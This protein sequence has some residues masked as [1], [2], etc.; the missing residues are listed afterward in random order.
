MPRSSSG[1]QRQHRGGGGPTAA[2]VES[3]ELQHQLE[4]GL[5]HAVAV[6]DVVPQVAVP[7]GHISRGRRL[8]TVTDVDR[9]QPCRRGRSVERLSVG[10]KARSGDA[11]T[12]KCSGGTSTPLA[13]NATT[14]ASDRGVIRSVSEGGQGR[15]S[16]SATPPTPTANSYSRRPFLEI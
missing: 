5:A 13:R 2:E 11:R 16:G 12:L 7:D 15:S 3:A 10:V 1:R 9:E 8:V 6:V 14:S 4:R